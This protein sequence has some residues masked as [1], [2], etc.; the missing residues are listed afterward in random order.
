M[1]LAKELVELTIDTSYVPDWGLAETVREFTQ[2]ALDAHDKGRP[3]SVEHRRGRLSI[4]SLGARMDRSVLLLGY[5]DKKGT[6]ARGGFG[7]GLKLACLAAVRSGHKVAIDT[8]DEVLEPFLGPSQNFPGRTTLWFSISA[9][10]KDKIVCVEVVVHKVYA[11]EWRKLSEQFLALSPPV[12]CLSTEHGTLLLDRKHVGR[13]Y[14]RGIFVLQDPKLA[15]GYDIPL[16]TDRDRR[17]VARSELSS[18]IANIYYTAV[19][20]N[21]T[22]ADIVLDMLEQDTRDVESFPYG[23]GPDY[24]A[25][26]AA[27]KERFSAKHGPKSAPVATDGERRHLAR[28]GLRGIV[29]PSVLY[30]TLAEQ[31]AKE[32][33]VLKRN[34][35]VLKTYAHSDL[36]AEERIN[37]HCAVRLLQTADPAF[38]IG[39]VQVAKFKNL[40]HVPVFGLH[41]PG[42]GII[43]IGRDQ[44]EVLG[45]ALQTLVHE[46][47][48]DEGGDLTKEHTDS[49][50]RLWRRV[51]EWLI[52]RT[53]INPGRLLS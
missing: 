18:A 10:P 19:C 22:Y 9:R 8:G 2:N 35:R 51:A 28:W 1:S 36:S 17:L 3:M 4:R 40:T 44:L 26:C 34:V 5:T 25:A 16:K 11:K 13:V 41:D 50:E 33:S 12:F 52:A 32:L 38:T 39:R 30:S 48:H 45:Q 23:H 20:Q 49:I 47:A 31:Y 6:D 29:V 24:D 27:L 15:R 37:L 43:Q 7:E 14:A 21:T 53:G 46:R 42:T